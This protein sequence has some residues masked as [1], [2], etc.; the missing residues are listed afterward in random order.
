[1]DP[2]INAIYNTS[3][4]NETILVKSNF[5]NSRMTGQKTNFEFFQNKIVKENTGIF[6][7]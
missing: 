1:M 2:F 3:G 7:K 4:A 6:K 5:R